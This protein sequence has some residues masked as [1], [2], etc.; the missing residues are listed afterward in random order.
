M[1]QP[2]FCP[3]ARPSGISRTSWREGDGETCVSFTE[4]VFPWGHAADFWITYRSGSL[5]ETYM[6]RKRMAHSAL[7]KYVSLERAMLMG[8]FSYLSLFAIRV[9]YGSTFLAVLLLHRSPDTH[10]KR[11]MGN[12]FLF[13]HR[14]ILQVLLS[15]SD[16]GLH[17]TIQCNVIKIY[18]L[19]KKAFLEPLYRIL[20]YF[21]TCNICI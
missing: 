2:R 1:S 16:C 5:I 14:I 7:R 4:R 10:P 9:S 21:Y 12:P 11:H 20:F 3:F 15:Q 6:A 19:R 18:N 8:A 13:V 17:V